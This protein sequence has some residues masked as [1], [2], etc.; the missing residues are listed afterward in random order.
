M[1]ASF[2]L[3]PD[4]ATASAPVGPLRRP[5]AWLLGLCAA[6]LP[7][8][9]LADG[10]IDQAINSTLEPVV[11]LLESILFFDP[12]AVLGIDLGTRVPLIL[13]WL[14]FG[15][16]FFTLRM[17]FVN[18]RGFRHG[19]DLV[20]GRYQQIAHPGEVSYFQALATAL[21]GTIGL[22][23]IAG[24]AVAVSLGGPGATLWMIVA[25]LLGMSAKFTECTLGVKYRIVH[26]DGESVSGGPMHYLRL[27]LA[28]HGHARL[29]RVL[30]V[31]FS[32]M[33]IGGALGAGNMFQAN[34][35]YAQA[36]LH[37]PFLAGHGVLF[38]LGLAV[39]V[40]AVIV[41][42]LRGI[43]QVT[44]R[45]V[46][47]MCLLYVSFSLLII[48]LHWD[49]IDDAFL[50]IVRGA[51]APEALG[52]GALG[53][54]IIGFQRAAF[55]NEAGIGSASIVH[56][57]AR[58]HEP[59]S[60]GMVALLEP[61]ID[62]VLICTMTC[63]VLIFTGYA[64]DAQGLTGANL[65]A[66]AFSSVFPW[67]KWVLLLCI[68]L[69]AFSTMLSWSYYGLKAWRHLIGRHADRAGAEMS[70]KLVYLLCI[71][72]GSSS[73]LD[74]VLSFADMMILGMAFPNIIGLLIL[75]GDVRADL[76]RYWGLLR[77]KKLPRRH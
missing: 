62:T 19:V 58:T 55:S 56:S 24:V 67:L 52:G 64:Q 1:P 60:E 36:A 20:M 70:Y 61:F 21:S 37:I 71:V 69:F 16:V 32:V 47:F 74:V 4:A 43:A 5:L 2:R 12:I 53:V 11:R 3:R 9:A 63:L 72:V 23:N 17:R 28:Q 25:G 14:I 59:I 75:S 35:A 34:Q 65:T 40:G 45:I 38:G 6:W 48:L 7:A 77:D 15:A 42:G 27:G 13:L 31:M 57:A 29:G 54:L 33:C 26:A 44:S 30:A 8:G 41:G 76:E 22:G 18:I 50:M 68:V 10:G 51:F 49:R 46:P 39:L 73:S 66:A